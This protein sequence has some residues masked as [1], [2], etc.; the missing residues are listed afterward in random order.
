MRYS[1]LILFASISC[2]TFS[3][4]FDWYLNF[5]NIADNREYDHSIGHDQTIFGVRV[6]GAVG[7]LQD[8]VSGLYGG[9][10]YFYEYGAD[11]DEVPLA[12]NLYYVI[13]R[14][15]FGFYAGSFNR[16]KVLTAPLFMISDT[17][18]Y[19]EPNM[20][21]MSFEIRRQWGHQNLFV[22][23][24]GRQSEVRRESFMAGTS[25]LYQK[26]QFYIENYAYMYH[27]ALR[28]VWDED[29]NI[30]DNGVAS[31]FFGFDVS[32]K[33]VFNTLKFDVGGIANY[34]RKR[35]NDLT[36]Q[37]GMMARA[38]LY[39]KRFG[40]DMTSYWGDAL[41]LPLGDPLYKNGNYTRLTFSAVPIVGKYIESVFKWSVHMTG[42][43]V[44]SSQQFV[45]IAKF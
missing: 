31:A 35:P 29:E 18:S 3:Q 9:V 25:G 41:I 22:D 36:Y 30:Q 20:G 19:Y 6:D 13:D 38:S 42:G 7:L 12:L 21:G 45:L 11:V 14:E 39:Y 32:D 8:S 26:G 1:L 44:S 37:G 17:I 4:D 43:V 34:D 16:K 27:Y 24:T 33:T 5:E 28:S 2:L 40:A 10:N 15:D 23:W